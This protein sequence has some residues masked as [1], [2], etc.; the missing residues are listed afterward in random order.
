MEKIII[1]EDRIIGQQKNALGEPI[2]NLE[3]GDIVEQREDG[4]YLTRKLDF[5]RN[6]NMYTSAFES[7]KK[8]NNGDYEINTK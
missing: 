5:S 2:I 1:I 3:K 8:W 7:I 6:K 4:I